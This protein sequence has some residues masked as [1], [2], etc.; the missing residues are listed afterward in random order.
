MAVTPGSDTFAKLLKHFTG[1]EEVYN[2]DE[3]ALLQAV[4]NKSRDL[5]ALMQKDLEKARS[6][7]KFCVDKDV[8]ILTYADD[9]YPEQYRCIKTPPVLLYYRGI[10]PDFNGDCFVAMVGTRRLTEYGRKNAY[11]IGYDVAT[12]GAVVVS[13]MAIGIDGVSHAGALAAGGRTVAFLG[14]GIDVCYPT[15][16]LSLAR[17]I[18]KNGCVMTEYAP[19]TKP[20]GH[21]FPRRNRLIAALSCAT[22][23]IEG[24]LT[25]GAIITA[26]L[27]REYE[28]AVFALPGNVDNVTSEVANVLIQNG[29]KLIISALDIIN[30][31]EKSYMDKLCV[32]KIQYKPSIPMEDALTEYKVSCVCPSDKIF[33]PPR[34]K[35]KARKL[36]EELLSVSVE[37]Q[38]AENANVSTS[39]DI[40]DFSFDSDTLRIYQKIPTDTDCSVNDLI[41]ENDKMNSVMKALLKLEMGR[42]ITMLPGERV[43]R[44]L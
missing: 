23:V 35:R 14:C 10:L 40:K 15:S 43:K 1:A 34:T 11:V 4:G 12:A 39:P 20:E 13:G 17:A 25:S 19:G 24:K 44:N 9:E 38:I 32:A 42:F 30:D 8:G 5:D 2:A 26:R 36:D 28:K 16:H 18:V 27:A 33:D 29:A 3:N 22:V 31:L 41:D 37:N 7:Y 21:N 6:V